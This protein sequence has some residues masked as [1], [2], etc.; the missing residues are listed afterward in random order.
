V[1]PELQKL[2]KYTGYFRQFDSR[3][4]YDINDPEVR[5]EY[6]MWVNEVMRDEGRLESAYQKGL[7]EA[8]REAE[9]KGKIEFIQNL[10]STG[11]LTP[12]QIAE[13]AKLPLADILAL[14]DTVQD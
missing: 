12:Q 8:E 6:A 5:E 13:A 10:L 1:R 9:L 4:A 14:R 7:R 3:G 11:L 2:A